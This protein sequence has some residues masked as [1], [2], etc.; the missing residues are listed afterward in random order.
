MKDSFTLQVPLEKL[1]PRTHRKRKLANDLV[2]RKNSSTYK[3]VENLLNFFH[4]VH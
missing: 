1:K 3:Y 2:E 4:K